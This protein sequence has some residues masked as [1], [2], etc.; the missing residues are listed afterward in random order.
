M[1]FRGIGKEVAKML[2]YAMLC[3]A[4]AM[5]MTHNIPEIKGRDGRWD[6]GD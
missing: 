1:N 5:P 6:D 3:Y 4:Y 2:L